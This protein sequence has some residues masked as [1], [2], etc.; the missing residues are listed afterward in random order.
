MM[1][2]QQRQQNIQITLR[3]VSEYLLRPL[4]MAD[5]HDALASSPTLSF[6]DFVSLTSLL[7]HVQQML[8]FSLCQT[9]IS[10]NC[11]ALML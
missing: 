8:L 5:E 10:K 2:K 4:K 7:P 6:E 11:E 9:F 3:H 1:F